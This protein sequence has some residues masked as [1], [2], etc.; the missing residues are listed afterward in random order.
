MEKKSGEVVHIHVAQSD[1]APLQELDEAVLVLD[2]GI[3][4]DRYFGRSRKRNVTL[5]EEERLQEACQ[6]IGV[7][8]SPGCSRRNI[9]VRGIELNDLVGK[10]LRIGE[11][12]LIVLELCHPCGIMEKFIGK[13]AKQAMEMKG[14][15]RCRIVES[16]R[17]QKGDVISV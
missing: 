11:A 14:G 1:L 5:V 3:E 16:G 8:Y 10:E 4:G 12:R 17:I 2:R 7:A 13:G 15:L 6:S 9:T